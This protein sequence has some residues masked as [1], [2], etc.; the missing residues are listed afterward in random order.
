[1]KLSIIIVNYNTKALL[2]QTLQSVYNHPPQADFE[3]FVVDNHSTD[4]SVEMVKQN[5]PQVKLI[6]NQEN[7]GFSRANNRAIRISKGEYILLLN[8]DTV[9]LPNTFDIMLDFMDKHPQVGAAGCKVLLPD[10]K[11]DLAC[12]R[13]FPTPLNALFQALGLSKLFPKSRLFAQYNLT[14]LDEDQTYSVDCLVGAFMLVRRKT[15]EQVGLLDETFFMYGEDIDWCYRIK[16]AGWEIYYYPEARII[17][18]KGASSKKKKYRMIYEF[19]RAMVIF[20][21]KHYAP[22][23]F[24]L[25]NIIVLLGIWLRYLVALVRNLFKQSN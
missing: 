25:V 22:N 7:E 3:V 19:H 24:V 4:S 9:V 2:K 13:S 5:F 8:S 6:E 1:M 20:Y 18:Y 16:K 11:L 10:G 21:Q 15:I 12:R 17:H 23:K 14:Y